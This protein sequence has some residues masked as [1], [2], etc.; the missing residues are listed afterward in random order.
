MVLIWQKTYLLYYKDII[1]YSAMKLLY[2][3]KYYVKEALVPCAIQFVCSVL[4]EMLE[5]LIKFLN[6]PVGN[7]YKFLIGLSE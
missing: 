7:K 5:I 6:S 4:L 1:S 2:E 3:Q